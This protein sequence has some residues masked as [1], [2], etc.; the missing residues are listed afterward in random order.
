MGEYISISVLGRDRPGLL[1]LIVSCIEAEGLKLVDIQQNVVHGILS[2]FILLEKNE[3]QKLRERLAASLPSDISFD[4]HETAGF[5]P[6][7]TGKRYVLT[8]VGNRCNELLHIVSSVTA[9]MGVNNLRIS[10]L[11]R[12]ELTAMQF[13][14]DAG[15]C[16]PRDL[17]SR[18]TGLL[19]GAGADVMFES[20][21]SFKAGKKLIVFDMDSTLVKGETLE[22]IAVRFGLKRE[23]KR[24]TES[25]MRGELDYVSSLKKRVSMLS[26]MP[27]SVLDSVLETLELTPGAEEVVSTLKA[28]GYKIALV[29]GGFSIFT[30]WMKQ[31][32]GLDYAFGN[33]LEVKDGVLTGG[34]EE[35]VID[36]RGKQRI[37]EEIRLAEHIAAEEVVVVGDGAND[38]VMVENAGLG[39][40]FMGKEVLKKVA[41]GSISSGDMR[42]L[43]FCFDTFDY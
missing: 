30:D 43:L 32:L 33:R 29:S 14:M 9:E 27:V 13:L 20:E 3:N 25:A 5:L 18:L 36:A 24:I 39:I 7:V 31:K 23:M 19:E 16:S 42:S 1:Q 22:E 11:S 2:L 10:F 15:S 21:R 38:R 6:S 4:I 8:V 40:A 41:D 34:L 28:M 17:R 37:I 35:P 12:G 26:G